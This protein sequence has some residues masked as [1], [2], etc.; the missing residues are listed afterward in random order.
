MVR[1]VKEDGR[2]I[3]F[4]AVMIHIIVLCVLV[5]F[6]WCIEKG[7]GAVLFLYTYFIFCIYFQPLRIPCTG[8]V[9]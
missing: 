5:F 3:V 1:V 2:I 9:F 4:G 7:T 6:C 8:G